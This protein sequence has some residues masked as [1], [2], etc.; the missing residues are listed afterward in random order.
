MEVGNFDA[1]EAKRFETQLASLSLGNRLTRNQTQENARYMVYIPPLANKDMA[2][3]KAA[4][5]KRMG[6]EDFFVIQ[7]HSALQWGISLGIFKSEE[8]ARNHLAALNKKGVHSA[9]VNAHN[10][11]TDKIVFQLRGLDAPA[12]NSL[13]K[14][15]SNF[16]H[17]ELREC[18]AP[19]AG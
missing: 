11:A 18:T 2:D 7:D 14:I 3:K 4:E 16:P 15:K 8:A 19:I 12:R 10:S 17:Q 9:R 1:T 6:I 13:N 5:L